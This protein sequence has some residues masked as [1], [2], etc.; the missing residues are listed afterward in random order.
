MRK[1]NLLLIISISLFDLALIIIHF[2]DYQVIIFQSTGYLTPLMLNFFVWLI[3]ISI[4]KINGKGGLFIL[5]FMIFLPLIAWQTLVNIFSDKEYIQIDSPHHKQSLIIEYRH[6][7]LGETTYSFD[8]YKTKYGILGKFLEG[9]S[10]EFVTRYPENTMIPNET[11]GIGNVEW[12]GTD[13]VRLFT[14]K[15]IKEI[16]LTPGSGANVG[17]GQTTEQE[18]EEFIKHIEKNEADETIT[19]DQ[20]K[21][22]TRYDEIQKQRW[23][24]VTSKSEGGPIPTQQCDRIEKDREVGY[25]KLIECTHRWEYMLY[26]LASPY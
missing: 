12:I 11:L 2:T 22:T 7:T 3:V 24:D 10:F 14:V 18:I 13:A 4:S 25:Y 20:T 8:F 16:R 15:G 17:E 6:F 5:L 9:E 1:I 26:P 21:L 19:V 23:I